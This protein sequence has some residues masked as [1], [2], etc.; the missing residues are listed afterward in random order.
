MAAFTEGYTTHRVLLGGAILALVL[1]VAALL[2]LVLMFALL[3]A[4]LALLLGL[5]LR[6]EMVRVPKKRESMG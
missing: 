4:V 6:P 5:W 2:L 3:F 1:M